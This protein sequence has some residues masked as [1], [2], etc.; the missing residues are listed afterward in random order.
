MENEKNRI[1]E[2][3]PCGVYCGACPSFNK[4]CK[5][6]SS[7]DKD[8]DRCSK[9]NCK[10]RICCYDKK[11]IDFCIDCEDFPCKIIN[12]KLLN[13]HP[14]DPRYTYR[15]EVYSVFARLKTMKTR[16]YLNF[17]K[18]R[19]ECGACGGTIHFYH[20]RCDT[21]GKEQMIK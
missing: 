10:I 3:A 2:V 18:K 6:C 7:G 14:D 15:H 9:W 1:N 13:S 20:Y 17:Q 21:C 11:G 16:E 4:S 5:G 19:W 8:Q 12:K